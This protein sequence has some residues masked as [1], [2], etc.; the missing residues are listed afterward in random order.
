MNYYA[1]ACSSLKNKLG[2]HAVVEHEY[3]SQVDLIQ[4]AFPQLQTAS[5]KCQGTVGE[6]DQ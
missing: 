2:V 1:G 5:S 3:A 6:H 4:L